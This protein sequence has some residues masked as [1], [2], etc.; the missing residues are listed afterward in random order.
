MGE[1]ELSIERGWGS[2]ARPPNHQQGRFGRRV[3]VRVFT[4][5]VEGNW[6]RDK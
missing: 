6:L 1:R 2:V 5:R 3:F 4:S